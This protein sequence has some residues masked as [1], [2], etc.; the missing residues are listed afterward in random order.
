MPPKTSDRIKAMQE[1]AAALAPQSSTLEANDAPVQAPE[2]AVAAVSTH[3]GAAL[4]PLVHNRTVQQLAIGHIAPDLR[5]EMR[6][7]RLLPP[8]EELIVN[9]QP[10]PAYRELVGE[11]LTLGQSLKEQQIQPIVVYHGASDAY[12]AARYLIL[13]GQRRWTAAHLVGME[14]LDAVVVDPPTPADRVRIQYAENED[15]EEFS[16]MERAWAL[17]QMKQA[18]HEAP[19]EEVEARLQLSRARRQQL[20]RLT[21]FTSTQQQHVA[22]LRLHETQLRSLHTGVRNEEL[23]PA[24][25][26][27][28]LYRLS[29]IAS[30]RAA[31]LAAAAAEHATG[32]PPPRRAGIDGPTIARLV[33]RAQRG[34]SPLATV[35]VAPTPR[36]LPPLHEQLVRTNQA[37]QRATGRIDT[38]GPS[39]M[40]TLLSDLGALLT[41]LTSLMA[42]LQGGDDPAQDG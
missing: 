35:T 36:W 10:A 27:A 39:D 5:P 20:L 15:R 21:A 11:L 14:A 1:R 25:V 12:P 16:D 38:L 23:I 33:A 34:G 31:A 13:V 7:P 26:D 22:R 17:L 40:E 32:G 8:P 18:M 2:V 24:Q 37:V 3:F 41:N 4:D 29:Q 30:E 9:D 42:R 6:Q 28:I 19:W